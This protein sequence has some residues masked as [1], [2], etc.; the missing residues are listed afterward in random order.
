MKKAKTKSVRGTKL[1]QLMD[2][3]AAPRAGLR[4][5][6]IKLMPPVQKAQ[7]EREVMSRA[8]TNKQ[9]AIKY[10]LTES[11]IASYK[12]R[13]LKPGLLAHA[14]NEEIDLQK[15][16]AAAANWIFNTA[17]TTVEDLRRGYTEQA[18]ESGQMVRVPVSERR[19]GNVPTLLGQAT[20]VIRLFEEVKGTI[21]K[22]PAAVAAASNAAPAVIQVIN[23]PKAEGV[24]L[25]AAPG[26]AHIGPNY[27]SI[28]LI[29]VDPEKDEQ[30]E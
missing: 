15:S 7:F 9:L 22:V 13:Y 16:S 2:R 28:K 3:Y 6:K 4:I 12:N 30:A 8:L 27:D 26:T 25:R 18:D 17:K 14:I 10:A 19:L 21:G 20:S 11:A 5:S 23:L 29:D 24:P 1:D